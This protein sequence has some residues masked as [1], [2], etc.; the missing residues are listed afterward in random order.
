[1]SDSRIICG[2]CVEVLG[3][4]ADNSVHCVVTSPPY[5]GLRDYAV[6]PPWWL[7]GGGCARPATR[8]PHPVLLRKELMWRR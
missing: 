4:L 8:R 5:W 7:V 2:D 3:T 6:E 1:M